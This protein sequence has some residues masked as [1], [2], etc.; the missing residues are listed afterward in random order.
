[1]DIKKAKNEIKNTVR[2]YLLKDSSGNYKIPANRQRPV[3][4]I[5]PP[6]I[7]K[8]QIMEQIARELEIGLVAYTI[9]HHTRQSAVGLPF[10]KEEE[11]NGEKYS[12]TEYTMSEI[13]ASVYSKIRDSGLKEGILFIDEINCVSETLAPTMLQFLQC[14]TFGNRKVPDGW[15][16]V[17][18][19]NPP[20]YNKSVHE[21]DM[22]TLDRVRKIEV[23]AE[24]SVWREYARENRINP[25]I[26]SY[27][28]LRPQS[29][30]KA[31]AD[32]DGIQFVTARGWEDLSCLLNVYKEL[33]IDVDEEIIYEFI[34]HRETARDVA[35]YL[36]LYKK[37]QDDYGINNI[38]AG[39]VPPSVYERICRASFDERLSVVN[40]LTSG[41]AVYFDKTFLYHFIADKWYSFLKNFKEEA[42]KCQNPAVFYEQLYK[43]YEED[44]E[45]K[46]KAGFYTRQQEDCYGRL[47]EMIWKNKPGIGNANEAFNQAS[48]G[49]RKWN[50]ELEGLE[51]KTGIA[52]E[53]VFDFMEAAFGNGQEMVVFIT[54]LAMDSKAVSYLSENKCERYLR[55]NEELM[56]GTKKA[57][58]LSMLEKDEIYGKEHIRE[59]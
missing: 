16:I 10:I 48:E 28:E 25:A 2:A 35:A 17:A 46:R 31:E 1:M 38:L 44:T 59:F 24:Y 58:I 55:Y 45:T 39:N 8:T 6:G 36:D 12:V 53:N 3:L 49:F 43:D 4:L 19:G 33:S 26:T 7:G 40:L 54:E 13:I 14:K 37:Y 30:Y 27:L 34:Q 52:L 56:A 5:G 50:T 15:I 42:E 11:F 23:G 20:E 41:L 32:V 51:D 9:T 29:F 57:Q 47:L 21:F 22:V 18:A